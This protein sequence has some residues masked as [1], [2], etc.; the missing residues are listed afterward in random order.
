MHFMVNFIFRFNTTGNFP[1]LFNERVPTQFKHLISQC[2]AL[3][4]ASSQTPTHPL[5]CSSLP[6]DGEKAEG[7]GEDLWTEIM[8][9]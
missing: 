8:T 7:R 4:L 3:T 2:G 1:R 9:V 6:W 5:P